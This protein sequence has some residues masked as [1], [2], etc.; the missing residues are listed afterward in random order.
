VNCDIHETLALTM[1]QD[2]ETNRKPLNS[3]KVEINFIN[4]K[5]LIEV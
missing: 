1:Y 4:M 3:F 2:T 5:I